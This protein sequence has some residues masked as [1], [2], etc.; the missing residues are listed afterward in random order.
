MSGSKNS[1]RKVALGEGSPPTGSYVPATVW[2]G[3]VFVSGQGPIGRDG[4]AVCG[5]IE[6]E[7]AL[8]LSNIEAVLRAAGTSLERVLKCTCY[9]SDIALFDRF[10]AA[11]RSFFGDQLPAR[12]TVAA[13]LDGIKVEIDVI[14]ALP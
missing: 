1:I 10:D 2:E 5:S 3:L 7:T 4:S 6:E 13:G 14:A 12:T 8:T 9:L 11:Y